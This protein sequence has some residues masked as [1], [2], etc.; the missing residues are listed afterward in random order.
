MKKYIIY[1]LSHPTFGHLLLLDGDLM[2][3]LVVDVHLDV[4]AVGAGQGVER[5][6]TGSRTLD[7][8][9]PRDSVRLVPRTPYV[10]ALAQ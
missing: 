8:S 6:L 9:L 7:L 4:R 5:R 1:V 10:R 3:E 2:V